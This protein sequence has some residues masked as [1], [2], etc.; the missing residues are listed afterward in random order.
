MKRIVGVKFT[1][2]GNS[3]IYAFFTDIDSLAINDDVVV[4]TQFGL[5][6]GKIVETNK[7]KA[8]NCTKWVITKVDLTEH[9]ARLAREASLA[10]IESKLN[11]R[12]KEIEKEMAFRIIAEKDSVMAK[13]LKEYQKLKGE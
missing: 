4:D 6:L 8:S 12:M 5:S 10:E 7:M 11:A 13:L 1:N 9:K 3:T 2:S